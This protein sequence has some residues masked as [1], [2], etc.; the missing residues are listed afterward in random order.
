MKKPMEDRKV[1]EEVEVK[2]FIMLGEKP[3]E[4]YRRKES[5]R[6]SFMIK[7]K[8][9]KEGEREK[10]NVEKEKKRRYDW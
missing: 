1:L 9:R 5:F 3:I 6:T 8:L 4:I 10:E 7:H 2:E